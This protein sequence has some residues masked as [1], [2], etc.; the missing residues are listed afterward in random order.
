MQETYIEDIAKITKNKKQ[1]EKQ[2]N[3]KITNQENN[4]FVEGSAE[5]EYTALKVLEAINL[6]FSVERALLLKEPN[7]IL[8]TLHIKDITKRRNLDEIRARI[9]GTQGRTLRTVSNLTESQISLKDNQ[10]GIIGNTDDI[11]DAVQAVTSIIQGSKQG[12]V[13]GRLERQKKQ[14]RLQGKA[15]DEM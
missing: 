2:L 15:I 6:N 9:I 12:N 14:K 7:N 3:V 8:Q 5:D 1:L 4:V 10:V 11:E 13:Y